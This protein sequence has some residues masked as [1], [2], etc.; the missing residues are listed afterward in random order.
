MC[1]LISVIIIIYLSFFFFFSYI[2][3]YVELLFTR[4]QRYLY[5]LDGDVAPIRVV[6][7]PSNPF[8][9]ETLITLFRSVDLDEADVL[10][11][12]DTTLEALVDMPDEV[13]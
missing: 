5:H 1:I 13:A 11:L 3:R 4:N 7:A 2:S 6:H 12:G 10:L 9:K 8:E